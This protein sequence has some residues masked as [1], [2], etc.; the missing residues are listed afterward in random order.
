MHASPERSSG[1][2][3]VSPSRLSSN[4]FRPSLEVTVG[5]FDVREDWATGRA[6]VVYEITCDELGQS[7]VL[8]RRWNDL[9]LAMEQLQ[10]SDGARLNAMRERIPR[11]EPHAFLVLDPLDTAFLQQRCVAAEGLLQ[12]LVRELHVS[13]VRGTGPAALREL[14]DR[15]GQPGEAQTPSPRSGAGPSGLADPRAGT[16]RATRIARL[17]PLLDAAIG[18]GEADAVPMPQVRRS[19][20]SHHRS[21]HGERPSST[22]A[23]RWRPLPRCIENR[24]GTPFKPPPFR[25]STRR[26]LRSRRRRRRQQSLAQRSWRW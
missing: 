5:A 17:E 23:L 4:V 8:N 3:R 10:R 25:P 6:F 20:I 19:H 11:F 16:K 7:W 12:A 18:A 13:V 24:A 21:C 15:G 2:K 26:S 1:W 22:F 14:L 9:K